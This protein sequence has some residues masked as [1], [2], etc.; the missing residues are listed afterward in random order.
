[1]RR[2]VGTL[3]VCRFGRCGCQV[4]LTC[5][6]SSPETTSVVVRQAVVAVFFYMYP[7]TR[8]GYNPIRHRCM[9]PRLLVQ[10]SCHENEHGRRVQ[11]T[12]HTCILRPLPRFTFVA[13]TQPMTDVA[14]V[15]RCLRRRDSLKPRYFL[16]DSKD[17]CAQSR[18]EGW[19]L[20]RNPRVFDQCADRACPGCIL[21]AREH[22]TLSLI[23][24]HE[25]SNHG[26][27]RSYGH[28]DGLRLL[29]HAAAEA[30][31]HIGI[32]TKVLGN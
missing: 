22:H 16:S 7:S 20:V 26:S 12:F 6:L 9:E 24:D 1:M 31:L 25:A 4:G 3:E 10:G 23:Q 2:S 14:D 11:I 5:R 8:Q 28:L 21:R 15:R 19:V 32:S 30:S 13:A 29:R 18:F 27:L 17:V